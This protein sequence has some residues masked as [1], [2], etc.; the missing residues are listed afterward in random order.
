MSL[1]LITMILFDN[2]SGLKKKIENSQIVQDKDF[3]EKSRKNK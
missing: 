3:L 2:L 1:R